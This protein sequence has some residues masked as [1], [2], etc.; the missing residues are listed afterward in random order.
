[1]STTEILRH[2]A[3]AEPAT[4]AAARELL[5]A[6]PPLVEIV[7]PVHNEQP[8][9]AGGVGELHSFMRERL[10]VP[11]RI[12][13]ADRAST[14]GTLLQA[15]ALAARFREVQAV[16]LD[17]IG[18]G[19]A[20]RESW[21]RSDAKVVA[22]MDIS[23]STDLEALPELLGPLLAGH[24]DVA[25]GTRLVPEAEVRRSLERELISRSYNILV[26]ALLDVGFSDA[27]CGFK[28]ARREVLE[29]LLGQVEDE[30]W[31]FDTELLYLAQR[32]K[33]SIREVPVRWTEDHDSRVAIVSTALDDLRAIRRLRRAERAGR[34]G[35]SGRSALSGAATVRPRPCP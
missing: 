33:L 13:I 11:F 4:N 27:Q 8:L 21:L 28:A 5:A 7:I 24:A 10:R 15:R 26:R 29:P 14:D 32:A 19:V 25:V 3:P 16:H 1:M 18:S 30:G 17:H 31:F 34:S 20:L 9:L 6:A 12:T 22:Y 35:A 2:A 23:L